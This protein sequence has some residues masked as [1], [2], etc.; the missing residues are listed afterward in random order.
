[1]E[2]ASTV[3]DPH[4]NK[5]NHQVN[6]VQSKSLRWITNKWQ[7]N[8]SPTQMAKELQLQTLAD[9]RKIDRLKMLHDLEH[10]YKFIGNDIVHR[11]RCANVKFKPFHGTI[12]SYTES[13]FPNTIRV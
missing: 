6:Q 2:Y 4:S 8:E 1:M 5:L 13:F 9:R 12:L 10:G 3:W 7:W 11:Q